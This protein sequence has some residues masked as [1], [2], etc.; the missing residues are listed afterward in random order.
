MEWTLLLLRV[1]LEPFCP[2]MRLSSKGTVHFINVNTMFRFKR[3]FGGHLWARGL[4][5]ERT[6]ALV[7]CA[8]LNGMTQLGMPET[9]CVG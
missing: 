8:V 7:K 2:L 1:M 9:V 3:W 6:E 4:E 5:T